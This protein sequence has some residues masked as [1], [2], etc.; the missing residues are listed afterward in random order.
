MIM[1]DRDEFAD[2]D[3]F[4]VLHIASRNITSSSSLPES[5]PFGLTPEKVRERLEIKEANHNDILY[6]TSGQAITKNIAAIVP[7]RIVAR[8][9]GTIPTTPDEAEELDAVSDALLVEDEL[10][11]E[12]IES[13]VPKMV[14]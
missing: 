7:K 6:F 5:Q 12:S 1:Q 11:I 3:I 8:L 10:A 13:D 9:L 14:R 2:L 4:Y